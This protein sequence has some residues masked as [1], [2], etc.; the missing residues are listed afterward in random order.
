M[1]GTPDPLPLTDFQMAVEQKGEAAVVRLTG[2]VHMEVCD[3]L[4]KELLRLVDRPTRTLILDMSQLTFICSLGLGALVA[5]YVRSRRQKGAVRVVSP[6][7]AIR[8]ML[9]VTKLVQIFP[10]YESVDT[11]LAGP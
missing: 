3:Q 7:P 8:A 11:A 1:A 9:E 10:P 4:Q 2:A 5:A 6:D